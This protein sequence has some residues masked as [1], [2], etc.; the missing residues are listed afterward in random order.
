MTNGNEGSR[1]CQKR[2]DV[3]RTSSQTLSQPRA[4]ASPTWDFFSQI[5]S[6]SGQRIKTKPLQT[7]L[8]TP[9]FAVSWAQH[10]SQMEFTH[11]LRGWNMWFCVITASLHLDTEQSPPGPA[12]HF[13][14]PGAGRGAQT[15]PT[16]RRL[17]T[18]GP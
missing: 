11:Q 17:L 15:E 2:E 8:S 1:T 3:V 5:L 12:A 7:P 6:V 14:L 9:K 4:L 13:C 16:P 18:P 10:G